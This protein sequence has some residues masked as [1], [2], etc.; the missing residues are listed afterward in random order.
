MAQIHKPECSNHP[1]W[2]AYNGGIIT[3]CECS[4]DLVYRKPLF[5]QDINDALAAMREG[6]PYPVH[7]H[8]GPLPS[9]ASRPVYPKVDKGDLVDGCYYFVRFTDDDGE[10]AGTWQVCRFL[11]GAEGKRLASLPGR[12]LSYVMK[13]VTDFRGPIPLPD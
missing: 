12:N 7:G 2:Q 10:G 5:L 9:P 11:I 3:P 8:N 13:D 1:Q 6:D 4:D